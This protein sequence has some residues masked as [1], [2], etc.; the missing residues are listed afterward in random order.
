M[1]ATADAT[2]KVDFHV[3]WLN[4]N[5]DKLKQDYNQQFTHLEALVASTRIY[6]D[7]RSFVNQFF[8]IS[9]E[10]IVLIANGALAEK[11]VPVLHDALV[12]NAIFIFCLD[13][14]K[15][16]QWAKNYAK[17]KGVF[18]NIDAMF[19][20]VVQHVQRPELLLSK[21]ELFLTIPHPMPDRSRTPSPSSS[22]PRHL[23]KTPVERKAKKPQSEEVH[24][25]V[26]VDPVDSSAS[27]AKPEALPVGRKPL[28]S[29]AV[30]EADEIKDE[31]SPAHSK[32]ARVQPPVSPTIP[33]KHDASAKVTSL[34]DSSFYTVKL[35]V[36]PQLTLS[37]NAFRRKRLDVVTNKR[38]RDA[39]QKWSEADSIHDLVN[40]I[41]EAS[42]QSIQR[43]W[44]LFCWIAENIEYELNCK[45][46][47]AET[48][49]RSRK[50]V[51]RGF[52]SLYHECCT[53]LG[54]ECNEISGYVRQSYLKSVEELKRWP[55]AWNSIVLDG[56]SYLVDPTWGASNK[57]KDNKVEDY[58]FLTAP[59]EFIYTHY[60]N[61]YQLLDPEI[62]KAEFLSLPIMKTTY[63][64]LGLTLV[65]PKRGVNETGEN[66]FKIVIRKPDH[67]DLFI[68]LKV[69]EF[70]YPRA[71][72][73][74]CQPDPMQPDL[75]NCFV[76]PPLDGLYE[77]CLYGKTSK[78]KSY[79]DA[80]YM[81]LRVRNISGA[82]VFPTIYSA[83]TE[84]QCI[85]IEPLRR[86]VHENET[87]LIHVIV[88][89]ANV[90]KIQN[91]DDLMVP[92]KG[93]YTG[94]V[95][96]KQ[97]RVQGNLQICARW[98]D[99]ADSISVLCVFYMI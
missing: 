68:Q 18:N 80:I 21:P 20:V 49:F 37:D 15:H 54:I 50:G 62:S 85:L 99:N 29:G 87:V 38:L 89:K 71:L 77:I 97:I 32:G 65:S 13:T 23:A 72:H 78:E 76:A 59:D 25:K 98:D 61:G 47:A 9:D 75:Y 14:V 11:V 73:T 86:F 44:L 39:V 70:E 56:S 30:I 41:Q 12:L 27:K 69:G 45:S 5:I 35:H 94:G 81:R 28:G 51:C 24:P 22:V 82:F 92:S 53:L 48:V 17:V 34:G 6:E 19:K 64:R 2:T 33:K 95:L 7:H 66:L 8:E 90:L 1:E 84:H 43:A 60:C 16:E 63:Y 10:K 88:P 67:V 40:K 4:K 3:I 42:S 93:E 55:H 36:D 79:Y 91:G 52:A 46:N 26:S 57:S 58:Y 96:R 83:F 31:S 74:L